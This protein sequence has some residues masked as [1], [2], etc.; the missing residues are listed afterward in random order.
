[1]FVLGGFSLIAQVTF[2]RE[3]MVA[4]FGNELVI[5][6]LLGSW[7]VGISLGAYAARFVLLRVR[8][9]QATWCLVAGLVLAAVLLWPFQVYGV[10]IVRTL[11]PT[12]P[13]EYVPFGWI[14]VSALVLFLPTCFM[15]GFVF[16]SAC[17]LLAYSGVSVRRH[18]EAVSLIYTAEAVGSMLAGLAMTY[19]L[20]PRFTPV[21][22]VFLGTGLGLCG[23]SLLLR[24]GFV[25]SLLRI[26]VLGLVLTALAYPAWAETLEWHAVRARW[27]AF[28]VLPTGAGGTDGRGVR[29]VASR[30]TIYQNLAVTESRGQYVLYGN[31]RAL[32]SF[33]DPI[34]DEHRVH[35]IMAQ[36]PDARRVLLLGGNPIGDIPELLKYP[37]L[38]RLVHV[39]LDPGVDAILQA[40]RPDLVAATLRPDIVE[41]MV[42][43]APRFVSRCEDTFD[44]VI[45]NAPDPDTAAANRFYT[46]EFFDDI[47]KILAADGYMAASVT[48]GVRLESETAQL[49]ATVYQTLR[50]VFPVVLVTAGGTNRLLAG[51]D[52]SGLTH[53]RR[54][55]WMRSQKAGLDTR[56][57]LPE[58]FLAADELDPEKVETVEA[59]FSGADVQLNRNLR[60]VTYFYN[61]M[62]WSRFSE[63]GLA[64]V[65]G[66]VRNTHAPVLAGGILGLGVLVFSCG[67]LLRV[68]GSERGRGCWSR[69][70]T[71][72][73]LASTG[74]CAMAFEM[75]LVLLFQ[76]VYGYVYTR[77]GVIVAAFMFGLVLG[78]PSG[79]VMARG[80]HRRVVGLMALLECALLA[81]AAAVPLLGRR[82]AD[83]G[84]SGLAMECAIYGVVAFVGW[85]VGAEFPLGN[86]LF[87]DAGGS[88][89]AAAAVTDASDHLGAALG[90][91]AVGIVLVPVLG[92]GD[93]CLV[94]G[95]LKGFGMLVLASASVVAVAGTRGNGH[96]YEAR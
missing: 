66:T 76:A 28:G 26:A 37:A 91:V 48:S 67:A 16:P 9:L 52:A 49:G 34:I 2:M 75:L 55:L 69:T 53:D 43:D 11:L 50:A 78:A 29:L 68:G 4:F 31:G 51:F 93:S 12:L 35:V 54:T 63:S 14:M 41:H 71:G 83:S 5:G 84:V 80:P 88:V 64:G 56:F 7:F 21:R 87:R 15:I 70:M 59:R 90:S 89:G 92:V 95:A 72:V 62:L 81:C 74:F 22:M 45:V 27:Q 57:F 25:R 18:G 60:P 19:I 79:R 38:E 6:T 47:R 65:L 24:R 58:Y 30:D 44:V 77:M 1:M 46:I 33:P 3:M 23:A 82:V 20:L 61:L 40:V 36:K 10:R 85:C 94:L 73:L 86:R 13:G 96:A 17:E 42:L 39:N 32:F 8:S